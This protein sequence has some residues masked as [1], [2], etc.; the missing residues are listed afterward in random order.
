MKAFGSGLQGL[1]AGGDKFAA[2]MGFIAGAIGGLDQI[3][4]DDLCE[5]FGENTFA[6]RA[7][8]E[9]HLKGEGFDNHFTGRYNV[10]TDWLVELIRLN[11]MLSF[12][13]EI[14]KGLSAKESAGPKP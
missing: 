14:L 7:G 2:G 12:L 8:G 11:G 5:A 6:L 10:L 4:L 3:L 9:D 1:G 13:S